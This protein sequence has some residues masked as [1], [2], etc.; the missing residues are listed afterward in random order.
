MMGIC[1]CLSAGRCSSR[2]EYSLLTSFTTVLLLLSIQCLWIFVFNQSD[3]VH[4][5]E[6]AAQFN[7]RVLIT[8]IDAKIV[9]I[10]NNNNKHTLS[11]KEPI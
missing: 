7:N 4:G 9:S 10:E 2:R 1:R 5:D 8:F 3:K 6:F 11:E